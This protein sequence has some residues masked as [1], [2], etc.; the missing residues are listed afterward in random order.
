M[1]SSTFPCVEVHETAYSVASGACTVLPWATSRIF[2]TQ[3]MS[4][5]QSDLR[6]M[7]T[8]LTESEFEEVRDVKE[9]HGETWREFLLNAARER[10]R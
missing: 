9:A 4:E 7:N 3:T 6:R 8:T 1:G 10:K 5:S 2:R